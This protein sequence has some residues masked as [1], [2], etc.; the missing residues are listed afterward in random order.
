LE[1]SSDDSS[2]E[3]LTWNLRQIIANQGGTRLLEEEQQ[4]F[5]MPTIKQD[6]KSLV[7]YIRNIAEE[8]KSQKRAFTESISKLRGD[9]NEVKRTCMESI[10]EVKKSIDELRGN[11][12]PS[13][14]ITRQRQGRRK[15]N[16]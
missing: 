7:S 13:T 5:T 14:P 1:R 12:T 11:T 3:D 16:V 10:E 4:F 6:L 2:Q 9:L 8:M 15:G